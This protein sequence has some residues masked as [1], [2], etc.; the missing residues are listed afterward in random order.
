[1]AGKR[2]VWSRGRQKVVVVGG[3]DM[4]RGK[5]WKALNTSGGV[6][7]CRDVPGGADGF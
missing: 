7:R 5:A 2:E 4:A 1:M 6:E 3:G